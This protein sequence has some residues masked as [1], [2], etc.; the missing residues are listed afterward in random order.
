M[1]RSTKFK[2]VV[3]SHF[4]VVFMLSGSPQLS[5]GL[6]SLGNKACRSPDPTV[7]FD[8]SFRGT[9]ILEIPGVVTLACGG[10]L[11]GG[12]ASKK[13]WK[14]D[15]V[16]NKWIWAADMQVSRSGWTGIQLDQDRYWVTGNIMSNSSF[17]FGLTGPTIS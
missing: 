12:G 6:A 1:R 15:S 13:C 9:G 16:E 10:E 8:P 3:P 14:L 4:T 11:V 2:D 17:I 5:T 7:T